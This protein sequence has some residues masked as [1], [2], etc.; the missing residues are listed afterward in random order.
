[1]TECTSFPA[2]DIAG[3]ILLTLY[4]LATMIA[5]VENVCFQGEKYPPKW[6]YPGIVIGAILIIRVLI[7]IMQ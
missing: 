5:V 1:M 3:G 2:A 7:G 6:A 4:L